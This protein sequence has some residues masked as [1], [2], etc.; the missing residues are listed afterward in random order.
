M[1]A[2]LRDRPGYSRLL[3]D[4]L[5][6]LSD[7]GS[8]WDTVSPVSFHSGIALLAVDVYPRLALSLRRIFQFSCQ[9]VHL[10]LELVQGTEGG[11]IYDHEEV[12]N[13]GTFL[14]C[15]DV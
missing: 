11:W 1:L 15:V 13:I 8:K 5:E 6:T 7:F 2:C 4:L 10:V 9:P 12:S 3:S 14:I